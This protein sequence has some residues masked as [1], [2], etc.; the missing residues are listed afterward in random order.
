MA[1]SLEATTE[2]QQIE[3]AHT[4]EAVALGHNPAELQTEV[5]HEA[6][7]AA[8]PIAHIGAFPI[9]NSLLN[10]WIVVAILFIF[11]LT[12]RS[13]LKMIPKGLQNLF[14]IV[15]DGALNLCDSVTNDRK[16]T[17]KVFPIVFSFFIFILIANWMGLVPG[18]GSIGFIETEGAHSVFIPYFRGGTADLNTTLALA[19]IAVLGSN[20]F[21]IIAVGGWKYFNKFI[22]L[23]VLASIPFQIRKDPSVIIV[24]PIKFFV[25]IVEIIGEVAKI[26]SLSFRLFGNVFAGEVLLSSLAVILAFGLP[27]PFMFLEV[28]VGIIQALIFGMLTLVYFSI[29]M[30]EEEH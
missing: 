21:G 30:T 12:L 22:N 15:V 20:I 14:E 1:H 8:E 26:A 23:K 13:K 11:A 25:G 28:I 29:A 9:T 18:I 10:T 5:S 27:I 4:E 24:N 3:T 17:L 6:T 2:V 7:L 19:I 16:K